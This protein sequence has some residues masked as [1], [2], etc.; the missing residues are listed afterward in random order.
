MSFQSGFVSIIGKP[1]VGKSTLLNALLGEKLSIAT[2][3][4][5]TTRHRI[6]GI[7]NKP[8][9]QMVFSDTPG[10]IEPKYKLQGSMMQ[11]V[12]ESLQ[13]ADL[14]LFLTDFNDWNEEA[15]MLER[16]KL[17]KAPMICLLNKI[18]AHAQNVVE[19]K[20]NFWRNQGFFKQIIP[21]S[22]LNKFNTE[23][24]ISSV[25]EY[26][27]QGEPFYDVEQLTD[28]SERFVASEIIREKIMVR[29]KE[30]IPYSV[31]VEIELFKEEKDIIHIHALIYVLRDSQKQIMIGRGGNALKQ[32]GIAA[33][34]D[35]EQFFKKK[36]FLKTFVK[37]KEDWRDNSKALKDFGYEG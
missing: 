15:E 24:L 25:L 7:L 18:D 10:I 17:V 19:D 1:N 16:L 30:E 6:K 20:L 2:P 9:F 14:V 8:N 34:R 33:R 5:Q 36:I 35:L 4:A 29:Y 3:K 22:A 21:I 11:F 32:V 37:V 13:D 12:N 27:P 26:L 23:L 28:R 31:Q